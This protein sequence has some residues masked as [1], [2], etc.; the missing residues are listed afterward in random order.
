[1]S[2]MERA[3]EAPTVS[4]RGLFEGT[5]LDISGDSELGLEDYT[6]FVVQSGFPALRHLTG[7]PLRA[8]LDG[9]LNRIVDTDFEQL[10]HSVRKPQALR[11]WMK[12]YAAAVSTTASYE[13]IRDAA[14]SGVGDKPS[15]SATRPYR[16]VLERLWIL[17]SIPAWQPTN[18]RFSRLTKPPKH[19]LAD[20]AL[21]A[22][23]LGAGMGALL[24]GREM[25]PSIPR[26]GTLLGHLFESLVTLS[27]RCYAQQIEARVRHF[28]TQGGRHEVDLIIEK[29]D[30][31]VIAVEVKLARRISDGDVKH[32]HW[33]RDKIG[34]DLAAAVV[35]HTGPSAYRRTDGVV[36]VPASLIGP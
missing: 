1:M 18:N 35:V 26:D 25:G 17:D 16:D 11:R 29:D 30:G 20:P 2:L 14:T 8:Q 21:A 22:R 12:A 6:R 7:R 4:L 9:Y 33:L 23:L 36:V 31:R 15:K 32:L 24:D 28:R 34:D 5:D 13:K 27:L 10:G 3:V 19:Q